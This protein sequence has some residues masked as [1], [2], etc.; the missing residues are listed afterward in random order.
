MTD[1]PTP[2][3]S[4]R[5]ENTAMRC[6]VIEFR[7]QSRIDG[8]LERHGGDEQAAITGIGIGI[9]YLFAKELA[10]TLRL[11]R[12]AIEHPVAPVTPPDEVERLRGAL[13]RSV[14]YLE[15]HVAGIIADGTVDGDRATADDATIQWIDE[16]EGILDLARAALGQE[17]DGNG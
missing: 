3:Q 4:E 13:G 12:E 9:S 6:A 11:A 1:T 16:V 7:I 8:C 14:E 2:A 5:Q 17:G 15:E 10:R